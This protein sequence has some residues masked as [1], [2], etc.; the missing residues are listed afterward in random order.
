MTSPCGRIKAK[1]WMD[2]RTIIF[3]TH[4]WLAG[5]IPQSWRDQ[6]LNLKKPVMSTFEPFASNSQMIKYARCLIFLSLIPYSLPGNA[7]LKSFYLGDRYSQYFESDAE[8]PRAPEN[9]SWSWSVSSRI[10]CLPFNSKAD[11]ALLV[12]VANGELRKVSNRKY[13]FGGKSQLMQ[14]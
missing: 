7:N 8:R 13:A 10:R 12:N 5:R 2:Y 4:Q 14:T 1:L 6:L 11:H 9:F 3:R